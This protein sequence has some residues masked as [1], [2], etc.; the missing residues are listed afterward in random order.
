[1]DQKEKEMKSRLPKKLRT[2]IR[3][4]FPNKLLVGKIPERVALRQSLFISIFIKNFH[5]SFIIRQA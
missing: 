5:L 4:R 1:M 2:A 3:A